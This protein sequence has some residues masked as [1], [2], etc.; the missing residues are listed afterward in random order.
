MLKCY[1]SG[2]KGKSTTKSTSPKS[3]GR[4]TSP[5]TV[6]PSRISREQRMENRRRV[7]QALHER[8]EAMQRSYYFRRMNK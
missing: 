1:A 4:N 5:P 2:G 8:M 6:I 3:R 7:S